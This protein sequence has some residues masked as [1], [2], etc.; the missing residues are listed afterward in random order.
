MYLIVFQLVCFRIS[1][2]SSVE[3]YL[4]QLLGNDIDND[5]IG[6][7]LIHLESDG[8]NIVENIEISTNGT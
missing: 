5:E 6:F 1:F 4:Y 3:G 7:Q 8:S 2:Y